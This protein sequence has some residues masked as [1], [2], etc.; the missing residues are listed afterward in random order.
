LLEGLIARRLRRLWW[1]RWT[2]LPHLLAMRRQLSALLIRKDAQHLRHHPRVRDLH[3]NLNLRAGFCRSTYRSFIEL[4]GQRIALTLDQRAHLFVQR[5][6][7][8]LE[9]LLNSLNPVALIVGQI[10]IAAERAEWSKPARTARAPA[11]W[12]SRL[13]KT[14]RRTAS[15]SSGRRT[16][17]KT[18][19]S[20]RRTWA[21][22]ARLLRRDDGGSD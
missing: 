16:T 6:I 22:P 2:L 4:A 11:T 5:L 18:T 15:E 17:G 3:L 12:S 20:W 19:L 8:L 7:A 10:K 1:W 13:I 14:G 9:T 21:R